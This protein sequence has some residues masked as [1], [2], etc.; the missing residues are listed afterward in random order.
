[1][2]C[3]VVSVVSPMSLM[4]LMA[5]MAG[6]PPC[7]FTDGSPVHFIAPTPTWVAQLCT[8]EIARP[9][10]VGGEI[11]GAIPVAGGSRCSSGCFWLRWS[12]SP[13]ESLLSR[14]VHPLLGSRRC[15]ASATT[16]AT[17][18]KVDGSKDWVVDNDGNQWTNNGR[19]TILL[20]LKSSW[21]GGELHGDGDKGRKDSATVGAKDAE[22]DIVPSDAELQAGWVLIVYSSICQFINSIAEHLT[23]LSIVRVMVKG[24][25]VL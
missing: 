4:A 7:I 12:R 25:E 16:A 1:M 21:G 9:Q 10:A 6:L 14:A 5:L 11:G 22:D 24:W 15:R 2:A 19:A 18:E 23:W 17:E 3:T 13:N 8:G 20:E